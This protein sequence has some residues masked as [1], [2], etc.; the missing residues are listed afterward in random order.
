MN[1]DHGTDL[2]IW[3]D[4]MPINMRT[5][6]HGQGYTDLNFIIP[7]LIENIH[8][9]KGSYYSDVGDFS[10][11]GSAEIATA[12]SADNKIALGAGDNNFY[13]ALLTGQAAAGSG[14]F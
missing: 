6:G 11:A 4:G 3:L 5:H 12:R 14:N 8:Y 7:E 10:G 1:L 9:K 13:R 2:A